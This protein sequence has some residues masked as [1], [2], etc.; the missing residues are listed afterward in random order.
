MYYLNM[1]KNKLKS[2]IE[3]LNVLSDIY[4]RFL[5]GKTD[6]EDQKIVDESSRIINNGNKS[7]ISDET[8]KIIN[9]NVYNRLSKYISKEKKKLQTF[10]LLKYSASIAAIFVIL[11]FCHQIF[12]TESG[13][14]Q[15]ICYTDEGRIR[16]LN[17]EDGTAISL[18]LNSNIRYNKSN[19]NKNKREVWIEGEVFFN[20]AKNPDKPFIIHNGDFQITVIGTSFNVKSYAEIGLYVVSVQ[21]G[22]V[23]VNKGNQLLG[24]LVKNSELMYNTQNDKYEI[25]QKDFNNINAWKEGNLV[26]NNAN[27]GEL[28]LRMKQFYGINLKIEDSSLT[29]IMINGVYDKTVS[30]ES[31]IKSICLIYNLKYTCKGENITIYR[32]S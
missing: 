23:Y 10:R 28:I 5:N 26:L 6:E 7:P 29:D 15:D 24:T 30:P 17:L 22:K 9:K 32:S 8:S 16:T 27:S 1:D 18:N 12:K 21:S 25:N 13:R 31:V 4:D 2:K 20:V 3:F 19:F 11:L 14:P